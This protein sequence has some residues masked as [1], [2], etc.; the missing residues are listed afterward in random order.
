MQAY[1]F[2]QRRRGLKNLGGAGSC[3][4]LS[5]TQQISDRGR[6]ECV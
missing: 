6:Y 3:N 5:D 4:F 2:A 1:V